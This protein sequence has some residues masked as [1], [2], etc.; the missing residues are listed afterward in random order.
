VCH[1]GGADDRCGDGRLVE[2]PGESDLRGL[3]AAPLGHGPRALGDVVVLRL[4]IQVVREG[5]AAGA[6][7]RTLVIARAVA[8]EEAAGEAGSTG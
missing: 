6:A 5:V 7:G 1:L 8:G 2:E 4:A 3:D